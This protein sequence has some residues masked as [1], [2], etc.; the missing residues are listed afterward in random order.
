[1]SWLWASAA[2]MVLTALIHSYLGEKQLIG[3][4]LSR[5]T[6]VLK[7]PLARKVL[8][9]AWHLTALLMLVCAAVVVW[10]EAPDQLVLLTG[11]AWLAIGLFDAIYSRGQH[12]GWPVLSAAGLFAVLGAW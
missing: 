11:G 10:P 1:M 8:R 5:E 4:L 6:T 9:F 12:V 3:P 2:L 7:Q